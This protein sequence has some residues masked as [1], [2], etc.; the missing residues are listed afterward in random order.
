MKLDKKQM[1]QLAILGLLVIACIGYASFTVFKPPAIELKPPAPKQ[2]A[3]ASFS[4]APIVRVSA[5]PIQSTAAFPDLGAPIPRRDPFTI[6]VLVDAD[7]PAKLPVTSA[8][9]HAAARAS[10]KVP[11]LIPPIG[12]FTQN[13]AV[14]PSRESPDPDP[15]LVLTGV[16][17]G[18]EN[19]AII[20]VGGSERHIVKQGQFI[21]GRY[22]VLSVTYDGAVLVCGDRL[23]H[24]RLG[25]VRNAI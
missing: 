2:A 6:Q 16:I 17:R 24:L 5:Q 15:D 20:R 11:P 18:A 23:I 10:S 22:R 25:G 4:V 3:N 9:E 14:V 12:S 19:V 7:K 1:P 8:T 21:G 13:L